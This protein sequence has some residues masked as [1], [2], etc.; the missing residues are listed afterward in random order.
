AAIPEAFRERGAVFVVSYL[1]IQ[2]GRPT[3]LAFFRRGSVTRRNILNIY[4]WLAPAVALWITG[5]CFPA[6]IRTP[7]WTLAIGL[8]LLATRLDYPVPGLRQAHILETEI[9]GEHLTERYRQFMIVAFGETIL[10][11][12]FR[13]SDYDFGREHALAFVVAFVGTV[14]LWRIY[15]YRAGELLH[16][17]ITLSPAPARASRA[18]A[19]SHLIMVAGIVVTAVGDEITVRHP[20]GPVETSWIVVLI[21]G[22]ALFLIGRGLLDFIT[23][24]HVSWSRVIGLIV[25]VAMA[26]AMPLLAPAMVAAAVTLVLAGVAVSNAISW[27][28]FPVH[29][30]PPHRLKR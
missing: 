23:F 2:I 19:V 29:P 28:F 3:V 1:I 27:R 11:A 24:S 4:V 17:A 9:G 5:A 21:G 10:S 12:G 8:E 22:A 13:F 15:F 25:L 7:L 6:P 26:P 18:A 20:F 30:R 14:L 16:E